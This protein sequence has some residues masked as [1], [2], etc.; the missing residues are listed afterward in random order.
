MTFIYPKRLYVPSICNNCSTE[1]CCWSCVICNNGLNH[2]ALCNNV[3]LNIVNTSIEREQLRLEYPTI[4]NDGWTS[5]Y[6]DW[7][8]EELENMEYY[9]NMPYHLQ[10]IEVNLN[11]II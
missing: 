2:C 1:S 10:F 5:C 7:T 8:T 6:D 9:L 11:F 3:L 4:F